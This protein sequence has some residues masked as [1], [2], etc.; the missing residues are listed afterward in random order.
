MALQIESG[1]QVNPQNTLIIF[2]EIQE[3][4]GAITSL[5]YFCENAPQ[6]SIIAAGSLL[7]LAMI[8]HTSFPVEKV[9]FLDLYPLNFIEFLQAM[10]QQPLLDLLLKNDWKLIKSFKEK[11]IYL[12]RQYY[13]I[14]GM[15][16]A[17]L[18]FKTQNDF[19]EVRAI[20]KRILSGYQQDFSKHA[21]GEIVPCIR[22]LWNSIP[23]Q[24]AKENMKFIY[25]AVKKGSRAKDYELAL[26][27]QIDCGL[28]HKVCRASKPGIPLKAYEDYNAFKL[29]TV[30]SGCWVPWATLMPG[31]CLKAM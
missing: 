9:E 11:Y 29:F 10:E 28:V 16:E 15:P 26:S 5:K 23:S 30:M 1:I 25:G 4:E 21:P 12:L 6:Y 2:D 20:Q 14:G 18:S 7:G 24:L 3:A 8:K 27:W 19:K 31:Y 17:V 13:Y 22:M